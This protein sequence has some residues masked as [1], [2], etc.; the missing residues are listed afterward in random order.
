MKYALL[1]EGPALEA[2]KRFKTI[3]KFVK[4]RRRPKK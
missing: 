3:T 2:R 4:L 1:A